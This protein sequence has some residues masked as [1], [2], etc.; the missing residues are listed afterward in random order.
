MFRPPILQRL[1]RLRSLQPGMITKPPII[2]LHH[3]I[4]VI[5]L[6]TR[7]LLLG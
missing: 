3:E 6:R 7:P 5:P 1:V 2:P 4:P